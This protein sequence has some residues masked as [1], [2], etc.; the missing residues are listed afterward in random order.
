MATPLL[1]IDQLTV[2]FGAAEVVR[3][4]SLDIH[5]GEKLALVGESGS[6]KTVM[7]QAVLRL[8]R[9]VNYQGRIELDGAGATRR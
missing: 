5:P 8:N 1:H 2:R 9:E 3:Q 6:G 7:A 4:V